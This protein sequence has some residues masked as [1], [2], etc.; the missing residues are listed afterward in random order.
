M[1]T[2]VTALAVACALSGCVIVPADT[3]GKAC[4]LISIATLEAEL[5]PAWH[6]SA[7]DVLVACGIRNAKEQAA[8]RTCEAQQRNGYECEDTK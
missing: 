3:A 1:K 7:G 2:A 4:H 8:I 5:S 6:D